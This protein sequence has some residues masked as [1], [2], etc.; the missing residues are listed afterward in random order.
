M[1]KVISHF[2]DDSFSRLYELRVEWFLDGFR[3][4]LTYQHKMRVLA[5]FDRFVVFQGLLQISETGKLIR[6]SLKKHLCI[7]ITVQPEHIQKT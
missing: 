7:A 5:I 2:V 1:S 3:S 4:D 6:Y